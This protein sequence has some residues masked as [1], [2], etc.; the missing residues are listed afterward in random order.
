[1]E[2]LSGEGYPGVGDRLPPQRLSGRLQSVA[3]RLLDPN[4][5][6]LQAQWLDVALERWSFPQV[7]GLYLFTMSCW[8]L[9]LL[10]LLL[11]YVCV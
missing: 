11:L 7:G 4:C 8:W 6:Y 2:P 10:L 1:M 9:V 3:E 5:L